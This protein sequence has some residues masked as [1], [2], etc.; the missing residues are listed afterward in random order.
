[1]AG[2]GNGVAFVVEQPLDPKSHLHVAFAVE[3]LPGSALIGLE[4]RK[5]GLPKAQHI[6]LDRTQAGD[7]ANA[8]VK[9]I[10]D[11]RFLRCAPLWKMIGHAETGR[12]ELRSPPFDK[13]IGQLWLSDDLFYH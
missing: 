5:L 6:R 11:F 3:A 4:L 10:R 12:A 8:E 7:I 2:P 1:M 13:S 9:L